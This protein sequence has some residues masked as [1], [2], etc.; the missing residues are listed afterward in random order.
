MDTE[1]SKRYYQHTESTLHAMSDE[2]LRDAITMNT[3]HARNAEARLATFAM[4]AM[5]RGLPVSDEVTA[6]S[7]TTDGMEVDD[8]QRVNQ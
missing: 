2:R 4:E 1:R 6:Y 7:H 5:R 3:L 8:V